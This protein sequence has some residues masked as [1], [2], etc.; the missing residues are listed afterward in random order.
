MG[1][2]PL[3]TLE[4]MSLYLAHEWLRM[5]PLYVNG[6]YQL[7]QGYA[8][9][10]EG[11]F[12]GAVFKV[13]GARAMVALD[14]DL[15]AVEARGVVR[16]VNVE[17]KQCVT[18][19]EA[20]FYRMVASGASLVTCSMGHAGGDQVLLRLWDWSTGACTLARPVQHVTP[21]RTCFE[22]Q[23]LPN[24][25][26]A[27]FNYFEVRVCDLTTL[28]ELYII[29]QPGVQSVLGLPDG[30]LILCVDHTLLKYQ[31]VMLVREGPRQSQS[32]TVYQLLRLSDDFLV[33]CGNDGMISLWNAHTLCLV[34]YYEAGVAPGVALLPDG[35]L[36][37]ICSFNPRC[38]TLTHDQAFGVRRLA[39]L[40]MMRRLVALHDGRL[41]SEH[42]NDEVCLW[43]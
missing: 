40:T 6:L 2:K 38:I 8:Y 20:D 41:V 22:L 14:G 19:F 34:R 26:L 39:S 9:E 4:K 28:K 31:G 33:S 3:A 11:H 1:F 37:S 25:Q 42:D 16:I 32:V 35:R 21:G 27:V 10:F 29:R 7:V 36:A 12:V 5:G 13:K 24:H 17:T 43:A 23:V 30:S 15:L 18:T